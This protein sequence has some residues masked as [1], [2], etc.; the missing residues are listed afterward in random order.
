VPGVGERISQ[1][2]QIGEARTL[3]GLELFL[4]SSETGGQSW[5]TGL[6][7][8]NSQRLSYVSSTPPTCWAVEAFGFGWSDCGCYFLGTPEA[9]GQQD[10]AVS[11]VIL[12]TS[13]V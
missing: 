2:K 12:L 5:K 13:A 7:V 4:G 8:V 9:A 3:L 1:D 11:Q 10:P 6:S